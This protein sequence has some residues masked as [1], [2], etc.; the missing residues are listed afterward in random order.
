MA[1]VISA[2]GAKLAWAAQ[3]DAQR[4]HEARVIKALVNHETV[5]AFLSYAAVRRSAPPDWQTFGL[6]CWFE[7]VTLVKWA[8]RMEGWTHDRLAESTDGVLRARLC[9]RTVAYVLA[10][11]CSVTIT[12]CSIPLIFV[13][14][15]VISI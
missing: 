2:W 4:E 6:A 11:F 1:K 7:T 5:V 14:Q 9:N 3:R 15:T 12:L 10:L 13:E 8:G